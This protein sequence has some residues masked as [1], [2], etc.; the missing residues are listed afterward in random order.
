M[1]TKFIPPSRKKQV[2][3]SFVVLV[4]A[5]LLW[6]VARWLYKSQNTIYVWLWFLVVVFLFLLGYQVVDFLLI[7]PEK[8]GL[9][10]DSDGLL[11]QQTSLGRKMGRILRKDVSDIE[12]KKNEFWMKV[13]FLVLKDPESYFTKF[14]PS[15]EDKKLILE[16][17]FPVSDSEI[18]I[19]LEE[20][21]D[22]IQSY[23]HQAHQS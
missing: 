18:E 5:L 15:N 7:S 6:G 13:V 23:F 11:F 19:S 16:E 8:R 4:F 1:T 22:Q 20:L 10:L 17:G 12:L 3:L 2:K 9:Y 21:F 14:S